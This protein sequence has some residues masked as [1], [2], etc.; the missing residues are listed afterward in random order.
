MF[1][2]REG[3]DR[4]LGFAGDSAGDRLAAVD[5]LP[6]NAEGLSQFSLAEVQGA[7]GGGV[8]FGGHGLLD[9]G[10]DGCEAAA[11]LL[12]KQW[13]GVSLDDFLGGLDF[14]L[15]DHE[16]DA[17]VHAVWADGEGVDAVGVK[18]VVHFGEREVGH[19]C[20][21]GFV[22]FLFSLLDGFVSADGFGRG[23]CE[24]GWRGLVLGFVADLEKCFAC[25]CCSGGWH[26]EKHLANFAGCVEWCVCLFHYLNCNL[27][28]Q[29]S[30]RFL[31]NME[32]FI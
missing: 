29:F 21:H 31:S 8:F 24:G 14:V 25:C 12:Y 19:L 7:P 22:L 18:K 27:K 26:L 32:F 20:V 9:Q 28:L 16:A 23:G 2:F 15:V 4:Q 10:F 6:G 17:E 3:A 30:K 13:Q 5:R 11:D 1:N